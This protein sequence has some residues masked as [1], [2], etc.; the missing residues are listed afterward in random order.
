MCKVS[1][2]HLKFMNSPNLH[3]FSSRKLPKAGQIRMS[4][5][6]TTLLFPV[7]CHN[8]IALGQLFGGSKFVHRPELHGLLVYFCTFIHQKMGMNQNIHQTISLSY[9]LGYGEQREGAW[10][11]TFIQKE[12]ISIISGMSWTVL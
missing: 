8:G 9:T 4:Y 5:I 3:A 11:P 10:Q 6:K 2:L 12:L 7:V 1:F